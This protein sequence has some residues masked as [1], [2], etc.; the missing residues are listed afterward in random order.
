MDVRKVAVF[1][2][3]VLTLLPFTVNYASAG[4]IDDWPILSLRNTTDQ[5]PSDSPFYLTEM[6]GSFM[7]GQI[8]ESQGQ[9]LWVWQEVH[10]GIRVLGG[11]IDEFPIVL[12][13]QIND[14]YKLVF[15]FTASMVDDAGNVV[16]NAYAFK[17]GIEPPEL[18]PQGGMI[19]EYPLADPGSIP[20]VIYAYD[21]PPVEV[22][23]GSIILKISASVDVCPDTLNLK[24]NG[25]WIS[26]YIELQTGS[27]G[28][29]DVSSVKLNNNIAVAS[30]APT[31]VGDY[32]GDGVADL[33][34]KFDRTAVVQWLNLADFGE[35]T[36]KSQTIAFTLTG[37]V[38]GTLFEG[39]DQV[40]I[41]LKG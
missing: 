9:P 24:S 30:E 25:E 33:M 40:K 15:S 32:D 16:G 13:N 11:M 5:L 18:K 26:C 17:E 10:K 39:S 22:G 3:A 36:G 19:D 14:Q 21:S 35:D 2:L 28:D 37:R 4:I 29:I 7:I 31:Q 8:D 1:F 12:Q 6:D 20:I 23:G 34:V 27:V 38:A 41:L